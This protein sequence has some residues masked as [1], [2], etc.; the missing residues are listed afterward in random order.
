[1]KSNRQADDTSLPGAY[2]AKDDGD[3]QM[4]ADADA[5]AGADA[6][7]GAA[8]QAPK[9]AS[10]D[11]RLDERDDKTAAVQSL[12]NKTSNKDAGNPAAA[13]A[14]G[15]TDAAAAAAA[16]TAPPPPP[17]A[18]TAAANPPG[19]SV[20]NPASVVLP[21]GIIETV[22]ENARAI[23]ADAGLADGEPYRVPG[24]AASRRRLA[25]ELLGRL[26]PEMQAPQAGL[27]RHLDPNTLTEV[28]RSSG[29]HAAAAAAGVSSWVLEQ[30]PPPP[31][32]DA[33]P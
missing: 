28:M 1:M 27:D 3:V 30:A 25:R 17:A 33:P 5:A 29:L 8:E 21:V 6:G 12:D 31:E 18:A 19:A 10:D 15:P 16:T 22:R 26:A 32:G 7:A 24:D 4:G 2:M 20:H 14:V 23:R 11:M 9:A 13:T